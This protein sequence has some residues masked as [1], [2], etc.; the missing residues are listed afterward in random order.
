MYA[1]YTLAKLC[2][3]SN[4]KSFSCFPLRKG[5]IPSYVI[6]DT[7][8]V[9]FHILKNKSFTSS[10]L[11]LWG[12]AVDLNRKVPKNQ[13]AGKTI[14]FKGTIETDGVEVSV[15]KQNFVTSKGSASNRNKPNNSID[16]FRH[17][18]NMA[19]DNLIKT[20]S[21]CI[22]IDHGRRYLLCCMHENSAPENKSIFRYTRNQRAKETKSTHFRKLRQKLKPF[23]IQVIEDILCQ[24]PS[25]SVK[26]S[27]YVN[28]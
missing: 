15:V 6:I 14:Q 26:F 21:N 19:Q 28:Y 22:L 27:N 17:I 8:I 18:E 10:K 13:G 25:S 20:S 11:D 2:E 16:K 12:E 1:F 5:S 7:K 9:N 3:E 24:I 4:S 23:T